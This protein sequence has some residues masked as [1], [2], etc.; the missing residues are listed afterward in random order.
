MYVLSLKLC[1]QYLNLAVFRISVSL[2][3]KNW[4]FLYIEHLPV[5]SYTEAVNFCK[6]S[7]FFGPHGIQLRTCSI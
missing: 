4:T 5:S 7:S 1:K 6:W 3:I 2:L